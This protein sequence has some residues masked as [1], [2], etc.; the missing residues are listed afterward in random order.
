[1]G[2]P[3]NPKVAGSNPAPAMKKGPGNRGLFSWCGA[4][5]RLG[6]VPI[7]FRL[8]VDVGTRLGRQPQTARTNRPYIHTRSGCHWQTGQTNANVP[9][10]SAMSGVGGGTRPGEQHSRASP[11]PRP[12]SQSTVRKALKPGDGRRHERPRQTGTCA[13][14]SCSRGPRS[15]CQRTAGGRELPARHRPSR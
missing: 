9:K 4:R 6:K 5:R 13:R 11:V 14:D 10:R 1:M 12:A 7:G 3:H 15:P 2:R 8:R